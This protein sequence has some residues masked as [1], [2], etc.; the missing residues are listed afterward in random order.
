MNV[1]MDGEA[2]PSIAQILA[3]HK[4]YSRLTLASVNAPSLS[5]FASDL[6]CHWDERA[7]LKS[8][9]H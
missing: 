6:L 3:G 9:L 5:A 4:T 8:K 2:R 7:W 1:L